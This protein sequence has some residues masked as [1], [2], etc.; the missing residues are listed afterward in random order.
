MLNLR[1]V[2][3]GI[4]LIRNLL[5]WELAI[6]F[7]NFNLLLN[8]TLLGQNSLFTDIKSMPD[9]RKKSVKNRIRREVGREGEERGIKRN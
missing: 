3:F 5:A 1:V 9:N 7:P 2:R 4:M 6:A 8:K